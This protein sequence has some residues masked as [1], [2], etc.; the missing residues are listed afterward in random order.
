MSPL[1]LNHSLI[2]MLENN[3]ATSK[4]TSDYLGINQ[5]TLKL[6]REIGYLKPGTH[7][8]QVSEKHIFSRE[9][10]FIYHLRWCKEKIDYWK[11]HNA[12]LSDNAA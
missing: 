6:W 10:E 8:R 1:L 2:K 5:K 3:W 4:K 11:Q 12:A 7:W 9:T